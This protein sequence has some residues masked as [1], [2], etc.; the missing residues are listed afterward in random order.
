MT[1]TQTDLPADVLDRA[2]KAARRAQLKANHPSLWPWEALSEEV[3]QTWRD[4][5]LAVYQ[6]L[7]VEAEGWPEPG[8]DQ[9]SIDLTDQPDPLDHDPS[10]DPNW[11][12][13]WKARKA[14]DETHDPV[15]HPSYYTGGPACPGCGRTIECIDIT[16]W[17]PFNPGNTVRYIWRRFFGRKPGEPSTQGLEKGVWYLTDEI[18]RLKEESSE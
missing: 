10:L 16:R 4:A 18:A 12:E 5:A 15:N 3:K 17:L 1:K 7:K 9:G 14:P 2:A 8:G 13:S 6:E 11:K